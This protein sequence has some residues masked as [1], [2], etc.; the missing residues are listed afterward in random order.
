MHPLQNWM[1]PCTHL[2]APMGTGP[3]MQLTQTNSTVKQQAWGGGVVARFLSLFMRILS[4]TVKLNI[5]LETPFLQ[6]SL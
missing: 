3:R 4:I 5:W 1:C 6:N 2:Q